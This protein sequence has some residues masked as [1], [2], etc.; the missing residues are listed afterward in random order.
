ADPKTGSKYK[1]LVEFVKN[2]S[3]IIACK[4]P[5]GYLGIR[6]ID[7][8]TIEVKTEVRVSYF[9]ELTAM[10]PLTPVNEDAVA[11]FGDAWT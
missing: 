9:P 3:A 1:I 10:A 5:P 7:P 11:K 2:A 8:Y 4:Q 6:A